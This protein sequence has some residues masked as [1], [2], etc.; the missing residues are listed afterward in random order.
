MSH[1]RITTAA[2]IRQYKRHTGTT[3]D[4]SKV[5]YMGRGL[6]DIFTGVEWMTYSRYRYEKQRFVHVAGRVLGNEWFT[7]NSLM[8]PN[9]RTIH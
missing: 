1:E 2:M 8:V 3:P 9:G 7:K 6:V 4:G 5:I